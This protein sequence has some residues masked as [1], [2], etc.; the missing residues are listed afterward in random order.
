M[1]RQSGSIS[2]VAWISERRSMLRLRPTTVFGILLPTSSGKNSPSSE[3]PPSCAGC[4]STKRKH[5]LHQAACLDHGATQSTSTAATARQRYGAAVPPSLL[6]LMHRAGP[7]RRSICWSVKP[8]HLQ[9]A[10]LVSDPIAARA[11]R[12]CIPGSVSFKARLM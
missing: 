12:H 2:S 8:D 4:V 5:R 10:L 11:S 9:C 3:L 1:P 6:R 7:F